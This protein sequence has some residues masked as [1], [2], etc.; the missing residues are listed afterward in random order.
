MPTFARATLFLFRFAALIALLVFEEWCFDGC[1]L[2]RRLCF[3]INEV[4]V[5]VFTQSLF[6][7]CEMAH[8]TLGLF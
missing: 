2:G 6:A 7:S 8:S 5:F 3:L 1:R 4:S